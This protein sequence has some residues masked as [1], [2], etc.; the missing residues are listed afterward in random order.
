MV[1]VGDT[2]PRCGGGEHPANCLLK[3]S[4]ILI[5]TENS[6]AVYRSMAD[7]PQPL[8]K[9]L[10]QT[11]NGINS[12]TILIA[13]RKGR[14]ELSRALGRAPAAWR[15][16]APVEQT[17]PVSPSRG[18]WP[19]AASILLALAIMLIWFLFVRS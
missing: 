12:G 1:F 15:Q 10:L 9:K 14:E 13:D 16:T 11:T 17:K 3:T 4:T 5:A 8:R 2:C 6:E 19:A 7:I 18:W